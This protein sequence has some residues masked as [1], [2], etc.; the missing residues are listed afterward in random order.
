M[1]TNLPLNTAYGLSQSIIN[2]FPTPIVA[3][4]DPRTT[5]R[6]QLGTIWVNKSSNDAFVLTSV[7]SN[8]STWQSVSG[9]AG[10]FSSIT[11][12]PGDVTISAGN[13]NLTLGDITVSVGDIAATLGSITA[14]TTIVAG[15]GITATTG[16]ISATVGSVTAGSRVSGL[17]IGAT[18]DAGSGAATITQFTNATDT[19]QG[20]GA[21]SIL[22][23]NGNP[24]NNTGFIKIYVGLTAAYIPYFTNIAP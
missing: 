5:D 17:M 8:V 21:L 16:N 13:L 11:V 10:D 19:T 4:R 20:V 15:T 1:A 3:T 18:G 12:T 24:G 7:V 23:T 2:V 22:S 6:A 9:G 14:G